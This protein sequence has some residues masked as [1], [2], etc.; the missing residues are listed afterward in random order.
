[1][2]FI[3]QYSTAQ[4]IVLGPSQMGSAINLKHTVVCAAGQVG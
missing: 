4:Y 3:N 1:M 2:R